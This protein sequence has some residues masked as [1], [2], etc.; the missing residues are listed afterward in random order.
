[1][2]TRSWLRNLFASR[3]PRTPRKAPARRQLHL[4]AL[5][6][7][8]VL[9]SYTAATAADL[10]TDIGLANAAGGANTITLSA[11]PSSPYTLT[12]VNNTNDF[13]ANGL[14]VIAAGNNLT[15]VGN[16][17]TIQRST[18]SGTPAFRLFKVAGGASLN[19]QNVTLQNGLAVGQFDGSE[20]G[21]I[22]SSG[23]LTLDSVTVT[24][25]RAQ[26]HDGGSAWTD[27]AAGGG[28]CV[29][30][31]TATL[32][33]DTFSGNTAQ[34]GQGGDG[35]NG[36]SAWGG[37]LYLWGA[38]TAATLTNDTFSGNTAQGG[39]SGLGGNGGWAFGGGLYVP[40]TSGFQGS[41]ATLTNDTFSGNTAHGGQGG[42]SSSSYGGGIYASGTLSLNNSIVAANGSGGDVSGVFTGGYNL[43]GGDPKLGPLQNNGGPTQTMALLPGSPAINAGSVALIP[44]GITTDQR[45]PGFP[46]VSDYGVDIGAFSLA[47]SEKFVEALF[48]D[49]LGRTPSAAEVVGWLNVLAGPGGQAAVV[50]GIANSTE[51]RARVVTGWYQTYLG[52]TP[53][54]T[55]VSAQVTA[56]ASQTQEQV[57]SGILG[58]TEFFSRAQNMG[59]GGTANQNYVEELYQVLLGRTPSSTE[60]AGQVV[61]LHVFGRQVLALGLLEGTEYRADVVQG[62]YTSLL[63]RT[64][65]AAEVASWVNTGLDLHTI[66]MDIEDSAEFFLNG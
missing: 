13:G 30:G 14:P 60:L 55:E 23:T 47:N 10:I 64:A 54:A 29:A 57:L 32:T 34:G 49:E 56:L 61:A 25:C 42:N 6:D 28:V 36:G 51:A 27:N 31:G 59:F 1:M 11:P 62:Y 5:E 19:L 18:A 66:R 15:I 12:A 44:A 33:N 4:E 41:T 3:A 53:S 48:R 17:D 26:G 58:S 22:F 24:A 45:G 39:Q 38:G 43:I 20:G 2:T 40:G 9:N 16:G 46:R 63:H 65:S 35:E 52:R 50:A 37:G 7:R 8:L 21:A